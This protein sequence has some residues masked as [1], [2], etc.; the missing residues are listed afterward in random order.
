MW[1]ML[2]ALVVTILIVI[3]TEF[4]F[5]NACLY[6]ESQTLTCTV[7]NDFYGIMPWALLANAVSQVTVLIVY[8]RSGQK[9]KN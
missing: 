8:F 7:T 5:P 2:V 1:F 9:G 4:I 6:A 3:I